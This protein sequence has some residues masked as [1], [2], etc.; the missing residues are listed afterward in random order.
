M[1]RKRMIELRD[2][3]KSYAAAGIRGL[4]SSDYRTAARN[5]LAVRTVSFTAEAGRPTVL[6]GPNGAGK[7]TIIRAIAGL[8]YASAGSVVVSAAPRVSLV[9]PS[10]PLFDVC[11]APKAARAM[12]GFVPERPILYDDMTVS[13]LLLTVA[14][15]RGVTAAAVP[16]TVRCTLTQTALSAVQDKKIKTLSK[17]Y[18][19]R[20]M[21]AQAVVATP[22][23]IVL[24]EPTNGLDPAEISRLR[25][26]VSTLS[27]TQTVVLSTHVLSEAAALDPNIVI[28]LNGTIVAQGRS[29][30]IIART[31]TATLEDAY[32]ALTGGG[33]A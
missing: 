16:D 14:Q 17:G 18:V 21:L 5:V 24:D 31:Q 6:L 30:D 20:L 22:P 9:S 26:L 29:D 2:F 3:S 15:F 10:A 27:K 33:Y 11:R 23:N 4:F 1:V 25:Q 8:H 12:I 7:T 19:Q 32:L 28:V 13:E